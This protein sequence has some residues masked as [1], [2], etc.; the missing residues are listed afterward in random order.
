MYLVYQTRL[1]SS[2]FSMKDFFFVLLL[3]VFDRKELVLP[4][5]TKKN[6]YHIFFKKHRPFPST[7][8]PHR[9]ISP[10]QKMKG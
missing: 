7:H 10:L 2:F 6:N 4:G 3:V 5:P 9:R 8:S 1:T